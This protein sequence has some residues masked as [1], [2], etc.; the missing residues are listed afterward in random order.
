MFT[1]DLTTENVPP[2]SIS[3]V[4]FAGNALTVEVLDDAL[5][6]TFTR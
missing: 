3:K 4:S 1:I 6:G 5:M 2:G